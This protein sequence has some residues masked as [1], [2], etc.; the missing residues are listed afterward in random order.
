MKI[1]AKPPSQ[2][3]AWASDT[4]ENPVQFLGKHKTASKVLDIFW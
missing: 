2:V 3:L 1:T 4:F